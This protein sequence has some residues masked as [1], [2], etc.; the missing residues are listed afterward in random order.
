MSV[1][2]SVRANSTRTSGVGGF[3]YAPPMANETEFDTQ[4]R[5]RL[6]G[7]PTYDDSSPRFED[8][9]P[10]K[11]RAAYE[12]MGRTDEV[13]TVKGHN[14]KEFVSLHSEYLDTDD[15]GTLMAKMLKNL[16]GDVAYSVE[17]YE[18]AYQSLLVSNS[19]DIDQAEVVKQQQ[20]AANAQRKSAIKSRAEAS[21]RAFDPNIDYV[22]MSLE[23]IRARADEESRRQFEAAGARGGND[24]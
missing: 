17:Q 13:R 10:A 20:A 24:W 7:K 1:D 5:A 12:G 4:A 2:R 18:A 8:W 21:A 11:Q 3:G 16:F 15:N 6:N 14:A 23:E 9:S 19:L 22:S